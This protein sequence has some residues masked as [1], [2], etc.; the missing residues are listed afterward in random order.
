LAEV[1]SGQPFDQV[2][3]EGIFDPLGM[4]HTTRLNEDP[5]YPQATPHERVYG[6]MA[7]IDLEVPIY[8]DK[9]V[10]A[11]SLAS[12]VPDM[13]QFLIAHLNQ[14]RVGNAQLLS[15]ETIKLM[16]SPKIFDSGD[17]G[18]QSYGYGWTHY[19][20]QPWQYWGSLIQF[21]GAEGHGGHD[22]GYRARMFMVEKDEGGFGVVWFANHG[23]VF[24]P[25]NPWF[26]TTYLQID[27]LLLEEAQRLWAQE[28]SG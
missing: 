11:G 14:G 15:P 18:M 10:G 20:E 26:F 25:D 12:N 24:K 1:V 8:G 3:Q 28:H 23:T 19:Q 5:A 6:I 27:T 17:V 21:L 22:I 16:H 7:K 2:L 9:R 4:T 13:A